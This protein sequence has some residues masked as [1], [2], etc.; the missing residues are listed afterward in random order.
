[1]AEA[2]PSVDFDYDPDEPVNEVGYGPMPLRRAVREFR[3]RSPDQRSATYFFRNEGRSPMGFD[4]DHIE[5][6]AKLPEFASAS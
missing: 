1:M 6:L 2:V 4:P 3:E 5:A